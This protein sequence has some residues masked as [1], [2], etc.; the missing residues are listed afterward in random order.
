M[1]KP[2]KLFSKKLVAKLLSEKQFDPNNPVW[3]TIL[4]SSG[5]KYFEAKA[6]ENTTQLMKLMNKEQASMETYVKYDALLNETIRLL[7]ICQIAR[8]S[9]LVTLDPNEHI[10]LQT[11]LGLKVG[12]VIGKKGVSSKEV[13]RGTKESPSR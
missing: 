5:P 10:V 8:G 7:I 2:K 11:Q 12:E 1:G 13:D 4:E 9:H 3:S 6:F